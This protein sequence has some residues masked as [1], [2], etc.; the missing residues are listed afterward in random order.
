MIIRRN[1]M[2]RVKERLENYRFLKERVEYLE[3]R[4]INVKAIS[5]SSYGST[6]IPKTKQDLILEKDELIKE[7]DITR[8]IVYSI[9]DTKHRCILCYRYL[10]GMT[11]EQVADEMKY[12][13]QHISRMLKEALK[14]LENE[15][16]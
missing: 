7:M 11:I 5:Y 6:G 10:D 9:K 14:E 2:S 4:L 16:K 8:N 1:Q 12:S 15:Y 3:N 13:S